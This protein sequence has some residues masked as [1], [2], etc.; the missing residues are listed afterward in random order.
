MVTVQRDHRPTR[1]NLVANRFDREALPQSDELHL[2]ADLT[3]TGVGKLGHGALPDGAAR[4][5]TR[6][7][8]DGVKVAFV[9]PRAPVVL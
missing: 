1:R 8:E 6:T 9:A 3:S 5:T 2:R 4:A 7:C